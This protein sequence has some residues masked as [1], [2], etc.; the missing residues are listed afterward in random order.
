MKGRKDII[1]TQDNVLVRKSI[2]NM[3]PATFVASFLMTFQ[4][5]VDITLAGIFFTPDHIA[6]IGT[7]TPVMLFALA[8]MNAVSG[9]ANLL[10]TTALGRGDK[11]IANRMFSLGV[12]GPFVIGIVFVAVIEIF[13]QPL[14]VLF[15]AK[16]P[17]LTQYA[18]QY[19]R[20]YALLIPFSGVNRMIGSVCSTYGYI[21]KYMAESI[22]G[23]LT[24]IVF[25]V[26]FVKATSL[27]IGSLGLGSAVSGVINVGI[28]WIIIRKSHIPLRLKIYR[29][30]IKE[31]ITALAHGLP[32]TTDSL[33]DSAVA[34][35]VNNLIVSYLGAAGLAIQSVVKSIFNVITVPIMAAG[36]ATGPLFGLFYGARDKQGLK[37]TIKSGLI[38]GIVSTVVWA[39]VC[40]AA[41]P[42]LLKVFMKN[43]SDIEN[44]EQLIRQGIYIMLIFVPFRTCAVTLGHFYEATERFKQSLLISI[45]PDSLI[46]PVLLA[47]L[48]P[49]LGYTGLWLSQG[50][51]ALVFFVIMYLFHTVTKRT[52]K[53]SSDDILQF[54]QKV[55]AA[56]PMFDI[57][58]GYSNTGVTGISEKIHR[59]M[60]KE[61][62]TERTAYLT[63]LCLE[64]LMA[65]FIAHSQ[66]TEEKIKGGGAFTD[67]KLFSDPDAFRIVIRNAA[68][69]YDPL[70]FEYDDESFSKIGIKM[71]QKFADRID[72]C[73]VYRM[74]IVTIYVAKTNNQ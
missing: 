28:S 38:I 67:V 64:E 11:E 17:E 20:C 2:L 37:K 45:I 63:A 62:G 26:L 14:V 73:Y 32:G 22:T 66:I 61:Y 69:Q 13:A 51:N 33:V 42:L 25:S 56:V 10:L 35:I 57:S 8:F 29:Y 46:Y 19:L 39:V 3:F 70:D 1:L 71:A 59:F 53:M 23:I 58:I 12:S 74:N 47:V 30:K 9:G 55:K 5:M 34:G 31:L 36:T 60:L 18:V 44:A 68:K 27:G 48:L 15:G 6:A 40:I 16:T 24:N 54:N 43:A 65:D 4:F 52:L 7:A 21:G 41:L 50:E 72:Y 49:N